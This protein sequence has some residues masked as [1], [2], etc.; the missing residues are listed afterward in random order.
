MQRDSFA[1]KNEDP[2][3]LNK[4]T[5]CHNNPIIGT[6]PTGHFFEEIGNWIVDRAK[7]VKDW[8][9]DFGSDA[10][11]CGKEFV[12]AQYDRG[13]KLWNDP[14]LYNFANWF[15]YGMLD[16]NQQR[17]E[18]ADDAYGYLNWALS[19]IPDMIKGAV[20]P[21]KPFSFNHFMDSLGTASLVVGA[22]AG[23]KVKTESPL[24]KNK[25]SVSKNISSVK[26]VDDIL[27]DAIPGRATKGRATQYVKTGGYT[28][29]LDDFADMGVVNVREIPSGKVG[30]LQDGRT[31]NVRMKSS[32][33]RATLEIY[34]GKSSIKIRYD[35]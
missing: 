21:E 18:Q 17:Y 30:T 1:G 8:A 19:G 16:A 26:S 25:K 22:Y 24:L 32:D 14:G 5:Y 27:E 10:L 35:E 2:L 3:S 6:D 13:Q 9:C 34:D 20:N 28:Q 23:A 4:Y 15:T 31:V 29:A 33:G 11:E 12:N 7:D